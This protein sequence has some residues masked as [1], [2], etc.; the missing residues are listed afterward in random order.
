M[1]RCPPGRT[2]LA[3]S[4]RPAYW[5]VGCAALFPIQSFNT[6][7][8]FALWLSLSLYTITPRPAQQKPPLSFGLEMLTGPICAHS[9][10]SVG[11]TS[12]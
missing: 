10:M 3:I 12:R 8:L 9:S 6:R 4:G 2:R 1:S 11:Q 5:L 7:I